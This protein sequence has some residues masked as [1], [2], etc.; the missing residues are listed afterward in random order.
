MTKR[1]QTG[2]TLEYQTCSVVG[3]HP[4]AGDSKYG[5]EI[6][7]KSLKGLG[8]NRLFLHASELEFRLPLT[9]KAVKVVAPLPDD[10]ALVLERL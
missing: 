9:D 1:G 4:L 10:L 7:D 2:N 6:F 3:G 5:D 8:L